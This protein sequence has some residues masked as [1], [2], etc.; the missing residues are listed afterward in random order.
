MKKNSNRYF[1]PDICN[2]E[3]EYFSTLRLIRSNNI[4]PL[5]FLRLIDKYKKPSVALKEA[6]K[7]LKS[8]GKNIRAEKDIADEIENTEK[9]GAR[10]ITIFEEDYP[11]LL[12][13]IENPP[14]IISVKGAIQNINDNL[15][16]MVGARYSSANAVSLSYKFAKELA[17]ENCII[18]SGLAKGID[19]GAHKGA[20]DSKN[21]MFPTIAVL[22]GGIDNIYPPENE[23]LYNEIAEKGAVVSE[24]EF[25]TVPKA[26]H[27]PRR[28]RIISGLSQVTCVI[29][30]A[31]RSGSL[32]TARF[33]IEQNREV[34]CVPGFPLDPRSEGTN[35][36]IKNGAHLISSSKDILELLDNFDSREIKN[37]SFNENDSETLYGEKITTEIN[38]DLLSVLSASPTSVD[39]IMDLHG[40]SAAD[41]NSRLLEYEIAGEIV[42]HP[43]NKVSKVA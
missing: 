22:A 11:A 35:M 13:E 21:N 27:F 33:A 42:R 1:N 23:K 24:N 12:S 2:S 20:L 32:I 40:Y 15:V 37:I 17:N 5:T 10:I 7:I 43:G 38:I 19:T 41:I 16:S 31:L 36:L 26:E 14:I 28:N 18:V 34:G 6:E 9:L 29:E 3:E 4:G 39:D 30:A 8:K 25:G